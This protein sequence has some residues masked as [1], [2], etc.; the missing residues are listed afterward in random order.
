MK[1]IPTSVI[2]IVI[3]AIATLALIGVSCLSASLFVK[4]YADPSI[5][6]ALISITSGL[7]GSLVTLLSSPRIAPPGS[8]TVTTTTEPAPKDKPPT[9]GTPPPPPTNGTPPPKP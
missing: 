4:S 3:I 8:Q 5:L 6:S 9:N 1:Q 2:Y 7:V